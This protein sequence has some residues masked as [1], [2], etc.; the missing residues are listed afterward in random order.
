MKIFSISVLCCLIF[1]SDILA[2]DG[3]PR[4]LGT[5]W[6]I[7]PSGLNMREGPSASSKKIT[8]IPSASQVEL[9][10]EATAVDME[11]DQV[12]GG[13]A[14]VHFQGK[15]GFVFD[16]YLSFFPPP[17]MPHETDTYAEVIRD[18]DGACLYEMHRKD[19]GGY[20]QVEEAVTLP[21]AYFSE[22]FLLAQQLYEIPETF[23]FPA[24]GT[25]MKYVIPNPEP[26]DLAWSDELIVH[27]DENGWLKKIEYYYRSE[28][29]GRTVTIEYN[30]EGEGMR[31][32]ELLVAD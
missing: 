28:G 21:H 19:W 14:K 23:E 8:T 4:P 32:S 1:V 24:Y 3:T 9:I 31:I 18:R 7:A 30:A 17:F 26:H 12:P 2:Q 16:G 6:V 11:V 29:S 25:E 10:E 20:I 22:A 13:M 15:E 5:Y 27:R